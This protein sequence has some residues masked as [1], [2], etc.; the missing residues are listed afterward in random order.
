MST[1]SRRS[2]TLAEII[3]QIRTA[4]DIRHETPYLQLRSPG[5]LDL[6]VKPH[7]YIANPSFPIQNPTFARI[8]GTLSRVR[9]P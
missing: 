9:E 2:L 8:S 5:C 4:F 1:Q 7:P 3:S 6:N